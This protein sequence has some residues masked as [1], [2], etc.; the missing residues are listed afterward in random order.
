MTQTASSATPTAATGPSAPPTSVTNPANLATNTPT[1]P[2][3]NTGG[4]GGNRRP[5]AM[6][7]T[8]DPAWN[9]EDSADTYNVRAW[10]KGFFDVNKLGHVVVRPTKEPSREVDLFDVVQGLRERGLRTPVLLHFSDL[11]H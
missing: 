8:L 2:P 4:N 7:P 1:S 5:R 6:R 9:V 10:G 11:L 3:S